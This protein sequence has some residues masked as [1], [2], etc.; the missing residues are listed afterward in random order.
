MCATRGARCIQYSAMV[1]S[2]SNLD[3]RPIH[4]HHSPFTI[5]C[6]FNFSHNVHAVLVLRCS[7]ACRHQ[8][9]PLREAPFGPASPFLRPKADD[10]WLL[11]LMA[12]GEDTVSSLP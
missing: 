11:L 5:H 9:N 10:K 7:P 4:L 2:T 8:A 3:P 12:R 1:L 6:C